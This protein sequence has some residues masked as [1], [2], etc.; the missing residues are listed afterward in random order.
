M[1]RQPA[2]CGTNSGYARH[3]RKQVPFPEDTGGEPCGCRRARADAEAARAKRAAERRKAEREEARRK[4][5][6]CPDCG[7]PKSPTATRCRS[8]IP[9]R[10]RGRTVPCG[11][12]S[13]Y[14][15]H[16][17]HGE[18]PDPACL[19]AHADYNRAHA[20]PGRRRKPEA[21]KPCTDGCGRMVGPESLRCHS[22]AQRRRLERERLEKIQPPTWRLSGGIWRAA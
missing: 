7:G 18:T 4:A 3:V 22:C 16:V 13:A 1:K 17:R 14:K 21:K 10:P 15:Y 6:T 12:E 2:V 5:R 11:T 8:C 20:K 9:G 19:A